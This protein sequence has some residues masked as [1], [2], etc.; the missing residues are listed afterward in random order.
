[1][2][3]YKYISILLLL[4]GFT[5]SCDDFLD[6]NNDPN[7]PGTVPA[8]EF[9]P[10]VLFYGSQL[11]YDHSEYGVYLSQAITTAGKSQ[12]TVYAY[13]S[14]WDFM[15]MSRHPQWRRHFYDIGVN[16]NYLLDDA[17]AKNIKNY[18]LVARTIRLMSTLYTT[19]M[20][21]AM[22]L[23]DAYKSISPKYDD[24]ADIYKWMYTEVDE[25][26]K[27][28]NDP[29]WTE[30]VTNV[31]MTERNDRIYKGDLKKWRSLTYGIKARIYL[32]NLPNWNP[33]AENC[34]IIV[35]ACD[36]ALENWE[37]PRYNYPS[38]STPELNCPWG[39][40]Q[41]KVN[42]WESFENHFD[43]AI[44]SKF[45]VKTMLGLHDK[46]VGFEV[47]KDPRLAKLMKRRTGPSGSTDPGLAYRYLENNIGKDASYTETNYPNLYYTD[48]QTTDKPVVFLKNDGYIS[49]MLTEELYLMKAEALYWSKQDINGARQATI[50]A[51]TANLKR[52]DVSQSQMNT[53]LGKAEFFPPSSD[54]NI[55]HIMRQKW[56]CMYLQPEMWTDMRR[57]K[58]SNNTNKAMYDG[59]IIY[60]ELRRPFNLLE[61]VWSGTDVWIQRINYDPQTEPMYNKKELERLGA[62]QNPEWLKKPMIWAE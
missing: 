31:K 62:Y 55:G 51:A 47:S 53:Y 32:R 58:Y 4:L 42:S 56:V 44:P 28:Y 59:V 41:P 48:D 12:S 37:E 34:R 13:K 24:Q 10:T 1:M 40:A 2:K 16:V 21:G 43:K 22:P 3:K 20:F 18:E 14:G 46:P 54:F 26:L 60:P 36:K 30:A 7:N 38:G 11:V 29:S 57:Y 23:S 6:V 33:T 50:D 15:T 49:L 45:F 19:D 17:R 35:E 52:H 27:L 39:P 9:L 8:Q 61:S 5:T 25:L